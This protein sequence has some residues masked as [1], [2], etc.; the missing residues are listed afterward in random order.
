MVRGFKRKQGFIV[1]RG[2]PKQITGFRDLF[3]KEIKII[4][5]GLGSGTRH[6]L[7]KNI[8]QIAKDDKIN[9]KTIIRKIRGYDFEVNSHPEVAEAVEKGEADVGLGVEVQTVK[10]N[11][12]FIPIKEEWFDF[13]IEKSRLKKPV[14]E[15]FLKTLKSEKL[16][17]LIQTKA[18]ELKCTDKTG[19]IIHKP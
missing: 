18:P 7:D 9:I 15:L 1:K 3:R 12:D 6:L 5:R 13:V 19:T 4:N 8:Q 14:I 17:N 10:K 2:N 16:R 11:L